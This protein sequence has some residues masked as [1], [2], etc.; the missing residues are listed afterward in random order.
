[1]VKQLT[2]LDQNQEYCNEYYWNIDKLTL[3]NDS[4]E[5]PSNSFIATSEQIIECLEVRVQYL[6]ETNEQLTSFFKEQ[7]LHY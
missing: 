5:G 3:P 2:E 6:E 4:E 7:I 1:M